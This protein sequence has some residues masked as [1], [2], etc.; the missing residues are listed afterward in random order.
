MLRSTATTALLTWTPGAEAGGLF[1][2][3]H[4][5]GDTA[6]DAVETDQSGLELGLAPSLL[7]RRFK[8]E[9]GG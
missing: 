5:D 7:F 6:V 1:E 9:G 8:G 2:V 3:F 4:P